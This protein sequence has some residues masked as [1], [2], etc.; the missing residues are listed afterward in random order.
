[1]LSPVEAWEALGLPQQKKMVIWLL[2]IL[3]LQYVPVA[4]L[5]MAKVPS[6]SDWF[7]HSRQSLSRRL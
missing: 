5:A 2:S 1:M 3:A 4:I 6:F 7:R